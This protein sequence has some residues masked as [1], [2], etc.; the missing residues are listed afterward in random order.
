MPSPV[1][2]NALGDLTD[3][4]VESIVNASKPKGRTNEQ[5]KAHTSIR[6]FMQRHGGI[7]VNW[8]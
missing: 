5:I 7:A 2:K 1:W 3:N 6:C 8:L 4:D